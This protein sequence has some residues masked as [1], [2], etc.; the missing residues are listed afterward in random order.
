MY[1]EIH[2]PAIKYQATLNIRILITYSLVS[3]IICKPVLQPISG[4]IALYIITCANWMQIPLF[5]RPIWVFMEVVIAWLLPTTTGVI[6]KNLKFGNIFSIT[7]PT[8]PA[9][10]WLSI[11]LP[12]H[13]RIQFQFT[14]LVL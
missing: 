1:L 12:W 9:Q 7:S 14:F 3:W 6:M 11:H 13:H 5:N 10:N 4:K 8:I 2:S